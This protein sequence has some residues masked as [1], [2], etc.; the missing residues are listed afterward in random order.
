MGYISPPDLLAD[1]VHYV[2]TC[3]FARALV[4]QAN[5]DEE[6]AYAWGWVSHIIADI[7][8]H[9]LI[10]QAAGRWQHGDQPLSYADDPSLHL[11]IE[12]GLVST[13]RATHQVF[14]LE[15]ASTAQEET[16]AKVVVMSTQPSS[17]L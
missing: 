9:P 6:R 2:R 13:T 8:I 1:L 17:V 4:A 7:I 14:Q 15:W 10:N 5:S 3:D 11:R 12:L 16:K